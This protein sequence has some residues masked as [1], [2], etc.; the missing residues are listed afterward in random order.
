MDSSQLTMQLGYSREKNKLKLEGSRVDALN[1]VLEY[2][3]SCGPHDVAKDYQM[4]S[5][6]EM[7]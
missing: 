5:L 6:L 3:G 4:P 1:A 7:L 2:C